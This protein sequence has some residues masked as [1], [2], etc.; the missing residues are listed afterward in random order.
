MPAEEGRKA[1][2]QRRER[3]CEYEFEHALL[4]GRVWATDEADLAWPA[5]PRT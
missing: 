2:R 5:A 3:G 1:S 4:I